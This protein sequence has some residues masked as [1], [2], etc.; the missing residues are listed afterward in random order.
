MLNAAGVRDGAIILRN[1]MIRDRLPHSYAERFWNSMQIFPMI[2]Y[3]CVSGC[4]AV[5]E[6]RKLR[7]LPIREVF[8]SIITST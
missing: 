8:P 6:H 2:L 1:Y 5:P 3:S 4:G 7:G